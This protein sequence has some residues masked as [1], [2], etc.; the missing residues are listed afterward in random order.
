MHRR[1]SP[2]SDRGIIGRRGFLKGVTAGTGAVVASSSALGAQLAQSARNEK[3][4]Q[5]VTAPQANLSSRDP[6]ENWPP[7]NR[8]SHWKA[9]VH[10]TMS[11]GI[12][13]LPRLAAWLFNGLSGIYPYSGFSGEIL[14]TGSGYGIDMENLRLGRAQL[15]ATTPTVNAHM[16]YKGIGMYRHANPNMRAFFRIGQRDFITFAV[17]A[18]LGVTSID[19][20]IKRKIPIDVATNYVDGNDTLGFVLQEI[21]AGYGT[22]IKKMESWGCKFVH[23]P[24]LLPA[25]QGM[26]KNQASSIFEEAD[27]IM[28]PY[29]KK[30]NARR[31]MRMLSIRDDVLARMKRYGFKRFPVIPAGSFPGVIGDVH[32]LDYSDIV[33]VG[34]V[35]IPDELAYNITRAAV[36]TT[37][38]WNKEDPDLHSEASGAYGN[39]F[40]DPHLMWRID[41]IPLHPEAKRYYREKGFMK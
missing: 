4:A 18:D 29:F 22:S 36:E 31:P 7:P 10:I 8:W 9:P 40:A 3:P 34:D 16:S 39:M 26:M 12:A 20:I 17:P 5:T 24:W 21:L 14:F 1:G 19:E 35:G 23:Y 6:Q 33:V 11:A 38:Q 32:T 30:L 41:G 28:W 15:A 25:F 37:A 13:A 2:S 27:A